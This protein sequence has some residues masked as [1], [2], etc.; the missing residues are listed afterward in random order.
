MER[1]REEQKQLIANTATF[2]KY[3]NSYRDLLKEGKRPLDK[4]LDGMVEI[5][6]MLD[7]EADRV[8]SR[9]ALQKLK[10]GRLRFG[11]DFSDTP[12]R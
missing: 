5:V 7:E 9:T 10:D 8:W 3:S 1:L 4:H 11:Q 6:R 12:N 2:Y